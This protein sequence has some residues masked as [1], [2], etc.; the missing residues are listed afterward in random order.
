MHMCLCMFIQADIGKSES[1]MHRFQLLEDLGVELERLANLF[2]AG[3][4]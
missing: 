1:K 3:F 4:A 2:R